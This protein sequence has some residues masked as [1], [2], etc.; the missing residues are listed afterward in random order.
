MWIREAQYWQLKDLY[1]ADF[2]GRK[3]RIGELIS[4]GVLRLRRVR[5]GEGNLV[6]YWTVP[7]AST[8]GVDYEIRIK[9]VDFK[10]Y[11]EEEGTVLG[12]V[13]RAL[14]EAELRADCECPAFKFWGAAYIYT[15]ID[16]KFGVGERR[17]PKVRNPDLRGSGCKHLDYVLQA[18]PFWASGI[19]S[20]AKR[21]MGRAAE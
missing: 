1:D 6:M 13:R 19:T 9:I 14:K 16:S 17:F 21:A 4:K 18:L 15:N 7:S 3:R 20:M 2:L 11:L 8:P 10:D 5:V 12:A